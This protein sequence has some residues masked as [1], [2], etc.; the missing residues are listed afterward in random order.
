MPVMH[1]PAVAASLS[2]R[3]DRLTTVTD[4]GQIVTW[5]TSSARVVEEYSFPKKEGFRDFR[6]SPNGHWPYAINAD[7]DHWAYESEIRR[8]ICDSSRSTS[9]DSNSRA[10]AASSLRLAR[11]AMYAF[12]TRKRGRSSTRLNSR[13]RRPTKLG[14]SR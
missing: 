2:P 6:L 9:A 3:L 5:D 1:C 11:M 7:V 12:G 13:I 8:T 10:M 4:D 14:G